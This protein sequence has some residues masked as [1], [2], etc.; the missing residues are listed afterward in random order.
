MEWHSNKNLWQELLARQALDNNSYSREKNASSRNVLVCI[1]QISIF[2][3]FSK[4]WFKFFR[5]LDLLDLEKC[6]W[7]IR[8][9]KCHVT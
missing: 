3:Y 7:L 4:L 2:N 8:F 9:E 5:F 6:L 1:D